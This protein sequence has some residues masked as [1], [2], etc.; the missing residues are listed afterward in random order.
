[1]DGSFNWDRC[2]ASIL[3]T[4]RTFNE[5]RL[6]LRGGTGYKVLPSAE[7]GLNV[8]LSYLKFI[9]ILSFLAE[10]RRSILASFQLERTSTT[11]R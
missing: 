7:L 1:M 4:L 8:C 9:G 6:E 3:G 5:T 11:W 10:G 2:R